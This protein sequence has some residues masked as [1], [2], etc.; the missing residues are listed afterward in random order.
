MNTALVVRLDSAG[1]VLVTGP[2]PY[3]RWLP[4][5]IGS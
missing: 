5:T 3:A 4:H 2:P 1:D